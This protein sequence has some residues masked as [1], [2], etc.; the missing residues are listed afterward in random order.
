MRGHARAACTP[1]GSL[2]DAV[3]GTGPSAGCEG[4]GSWP[5]RRQVRALPPAR[6]AG[7]VERPCTCC[8][9]QRAAGGR[10]RGQPADVADG[11]APLDRRR[12]AQP[13]ARGDS[14]IL[15]S[16]GPG[17]AEQAKRSEASSP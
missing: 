17:R 1:L 15:G 6:G 3:F 9:V 10:V 7:L 2:A 8:R 13:R 16:V 12:L 11:A 5:R 14:D 4:V